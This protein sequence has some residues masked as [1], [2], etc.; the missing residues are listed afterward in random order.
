M[1]QERLLN[2]L[3]SPHQTEKAVRIA[4]KSRQFVFKVMKDANKVEI[5]NAVEQLFNVK[6]KNISIVNVKAK[7]KRFKQIVGKRKG[8]KKAYV[9]LQEG[10]DINFTESG[11]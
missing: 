5:K 4:D 7:I 11:N 10:F 6:V 9:T 8:W 3:L 2:V 1:N